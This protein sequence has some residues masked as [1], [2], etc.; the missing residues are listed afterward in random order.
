MGFKVSVIYKLDFEDTPYEGLEVR[1][2]SLPIGKLREIVKF[3]QLK[4]KQDIA[5]I[6]DMLDEMLEK[7]GAALVDWNAE[8]EDE[9]GNDVPLPANVDGLKQLDTNLAMTI[10]LAWI[11]AVAGVTAGS[12]LGKDSSSGEPSRAL[13]LP[14]EPLSTSP[15]S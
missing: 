10:I 1:A 8:G 4:D 11:E 2:R 3:A 14:M 13:S 9:E 5:L 12:D 6:T 15:T 7:F